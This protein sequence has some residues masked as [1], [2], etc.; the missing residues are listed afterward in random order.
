ML[1]A[2]EFLL[3][4]KETLKDHKVMLLRNDERAMARG[5]D[6]GHWT[7]LIIGAI[8]LLIVV[9]ALMPTLVNALEDYNATDATIGPVLVVLVPVLIG[10]AIL[11]VFVFGFLPSR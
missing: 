10:V 8:G 11:L 5:M 1:Q 7:S 4:E 6:V 2:Q 9:A 3:S